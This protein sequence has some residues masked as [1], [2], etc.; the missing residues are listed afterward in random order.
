MDQFVRKIDRFIEKEKLLDGGETVVL[1]VSGGADSTALFYALIAL[2]E[3]YA[4]TLK[5]VHI[6]HGLREE[7][8]EEAKSV[9]RQCGEQG[10]PFFLYEYDVSK[11]AA[12]RGKGT[13]ETG[14]ELRYEAFHEVLGE[15]GIRG[16]GKIAVAHNM[17]D[18]AE[19][20]LFHLFRGTGISGL[21]SIPPARDC[22]IRPLLCV[23]RDEI[24]AFLGEKGISF[25]TDRTN[26]SDEYTRNRIRNNILPL[27]KEEVSPKAVEHMAETAGQLRELDVFVDKLAENAY[28][29]CIT[30]EGPDEIS[31]DALKFKAL[32][33]YLQKV[34][35]KKT[36]DR[37]VPHNRD[38]TH[39]HLESVTELAGGSGTKEV[40]L[41]YDLKG[42]CSYGKLGIKRNS[43]PGSFSGEYEV[44]DGSEFSTAAGTFKCNIIDR[45]ED[46]EPGRKTYTKYFDYAKIKKYLVLRTRKEGDYI[47]VNSGGSHQKLKDYLINEKVPKT[48]RDSVPVLADGSHIWWVVGHRI[49]EDVK[50]TEETTLILK[51]TLLGKEDENA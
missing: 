24:E 19:T 11:I 27:V 21:S 29:M 22:I 10:I 50:V 32:D 47:T 33:P 6:N 34:L 28:S 13:E 43:S 1:G 16:K 41:P 49:S 4:L 44:E 45:K 18:R 14:R 3:K 15:D 31:Y 17:N 40:D 5:V 9:Q 46:F 36:I 48:D 42:F 23:T 37:L 8:A 39:L 26:F 38:I 51:I 20:M 7:A 12:E 35:V 30:Y 25:A 2:R